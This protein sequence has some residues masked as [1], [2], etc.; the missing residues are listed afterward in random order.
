MKINQEKLNDYLK[1]LTPHVCP[2]CGK[3]PW[4][5][6]NTVFQLIEYNQNSIVI[7]G[8]VLPVIPICCENCGNTYFVNTL[9]A[10]LTD[11]PQQN[12]EEASH[13]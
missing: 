7:G 2:L 5:A 4:V 10:K 1:K 12:T 6:G 11:L 13:E 8:P 9:I 3:G